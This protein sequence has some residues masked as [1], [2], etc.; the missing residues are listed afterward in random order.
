MQFDAA[1]RVGVKITAKDVEQLLP[2]LAG[3][4]FQTWRRLP[5]Q[6]LVEGYLPTSSL[7]AAN[8][9]SSAGLLGV[10]PMYRPMTSGVGSFTDEADNDLETDR[11]RAATPG[12]NG[13]G[14]NGRRPQRQL[15]QP[16]RRRPPTSPAAICPPPA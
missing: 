13:T 15:Q 10:L 9:L 5:A 6:H 4:G 16:G 12:Y 2:S 7:V 1:G 3:L 11:V 8:G 14:V